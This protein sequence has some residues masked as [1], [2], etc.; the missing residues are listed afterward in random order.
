MK[1]DPSL[2]Q[3]SESSLSLKEE[4]FIK[5]S[6]ESTITIA[7]FL[8]AKNSDGSYNDLLIKTLKYLK[9]KDKSDKRYNTVLPNL[10]RNYIL[11]C[12]DVNILIDILGIEALKDSFR[13]INIDR[14]LNAI[15][16][17]IATSDFEFFEKIK[18]VIFDYIEQKGHDSGLNLELMRLF[19]SIKNSNISKRFLTDLGPENIISYLNIEDKN[20]ELVYLLLKNPILVK[21]ILNDEILHQMILKYR[22]I[23]NKNIIFTAINCISEDREKCGDDAL[24]RSIF[25]NRESIL[26]V[27]L[28]NICKFYPDFLGKEINGDTI[29]EKNDENP[30]NYAFKKSE[31]VIFLCILKSVAP[32]FIEEIIEKG[33]KSQDAETS[34]FFSTIAAEIG[35]GAKFIP[36]EKLTAQSCCSQMLLSHFRSRKSFSELFKNIRSQN[37]DSEDGYKNTALIFNILNDNECLDFNT[38]NKSF[39]ENSLRIYGVD[40]VIYILTNSKIINFDFRFRGNSNLLHIVSKR[41][42]P[43]CAVFKEIFRIQPQL[44]FI[45]NDKGQLPVDYVFHGERKVLT[46]KFSKAFSEVSGYVFDGKNNFMHVVFEKLKEQK[47]HKGINEFIKFHPQIF[48]QLLNAQNDNFLTP[49]QFL[50]NKFIKEEDKALKINYALCLWAIICNNSLKTDMVYDQKVDVFEYARQSADFKDLPE[51]KLPMVD[52]K[53]VIKNIKENGNLKYVLRLKKLGL[54]ATINEE[55]TD[56]LFRVVCKSLEIKLE[57]SNIDDIISFF[58]DTAISKEKLIIFTFENNLFEKARDLKEK[59]FAKQKDYNLS[60]QENIKATIIGIIE[61]GNFDEKKNKQ[62]ANIFPN[63]FAKAADEKDLMLKIFRHC[64]ERVVE[65]LFDKVLKLTEKDAKFKEKIKES[66]G[67]N[68]KIDFTNREIKNSIFPFIQKVFKNEAKR[69]YDEISRISQTKKFPTEPEE[70]ESKKEEL[71]SQASYGATGEYISKDNFDY[72]KEEFL[73]ILRNKSIKQIKSYLQKNKAGIVFYL[74]NDVA[75]KKEFTKQIVEILSCRQDL[76]EE[77]GV[78]REGDKAVFEDDYE[79]KFYEEEGRL[80]QKLS[81]IFDGILSKENIDEIFVYEDKFEPL[82]ARLK[83]AVINEK[84]SQEEKKV[85]PSNIAAGTNGAVNLSAALERHF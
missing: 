57:E 63:V 31:P 1:N 39:L 9:P 58:Q 78:K 73:V 84:K 74:Q 4:R 80:Q 52:L 24:E 48:T 30:L 67:A 61:S 51:H 69:V 49:T 38:K 19:F 22:D 77:V 34:I 18:P 85:L 7:A 43:D 27:S 14:F 60:Q 59:L 36:L 64:D 76:K 16:F 66:L 35:I 42:D 5:D 71:Y 46:D 20:H 40:T 41:E 10:F 72:L 75:Q 21:D 33:I 53:E 17:L 26:A 29:F 47:M 15:S 25:I 45:A 3:D 82:L 12:N 55:E 70:V 44:L 32:D 11:S 56:N 50:Y 79:K 81:N 37:D 65:S 2:K 28:E 6:S 62:S 13:D 23:N 54:L 8:S 68:N 83:E